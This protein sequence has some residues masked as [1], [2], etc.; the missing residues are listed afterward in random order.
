MPQE[1][2]R[3]LQLWIAFNAI[4][5]G[6]ADARERAR[7]KAAIRK[8]ISEAAARR[9]LGRTDVA[10][11]RILATPPGDT[12]LGPF[13]AEF[14]RA[15]REQA[16]LYKT[17]KRALDKLVAT[18]GILYQVRCNLVHGGKHPVDVRDQMLVRESARVL[19]V[20]VPELES[21]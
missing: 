15:S 13:D 21:D 7:I 3:F 2:T 18:G 12:R 6:E 11:D 20:L 5:G 14:R 4:Y 1:W 17:S 19:E 9:I 16:R 10:I 8:N